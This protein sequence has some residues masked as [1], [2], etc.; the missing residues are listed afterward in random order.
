MNLRTGLN[1]QDKY[2]VLR[3]KLNS[4]TLRLN[5][6]DQRY[7]FH[8]KTHVK[9]SSRLQKVINR[10][11]DKYYQIAKPDERLFTIIYTLFQGK[12]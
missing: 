5:D 12:K 2:R 8:N 4:I 7:F 9:T 1:E 10:N 3:P 6:T 11:A